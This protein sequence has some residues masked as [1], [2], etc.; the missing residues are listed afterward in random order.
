[1]LEQITKFINN[2]NKVQKI[3]VFGGIGL[4]AAIIIGFLLFTT[5]KSEDKKL[6]FIIASNLTQADVMRAS[7]E[8]EAAGIEFIITGSGS[9]LTLK[10]SQEFVNIAKIKLVTSEASTN[11]H[12]GWEIFEKSTIGTTNFENKVK[13]LRALEGE[14]SKSLEALSS[15]LKANVKIAIPK[16]TIFTEKKADTTASAVITLRQGLYLTQKQI[17]GIKNFIASAV[18]ELKV[19]N[20]QLIDS[21]G[22]LLEL[23]ADD[24]NNQRS[25]IQTKYKEKFE[26]DYE[27]KIIT[28][29]EPVVGY[30]RVVAKVNVNLDFV[31]KDIEEE[32]FAP[33]GTVRSQQVIESSNSATGM[34]DEIE[35]VGV[36]NNIQPPQ[37]A[38]EGNKVSSEGESSNTVTNYEISRKL[39]SQK[40]AN[41]TNIRRVTAS[42][43]FDSMVLKDHPNKEEF[44]SSLES[45]VE[46]AIGYDKNRGDKVSVKD[47]KFVGLK[48]YNENGELVDEFG[49]V[50]T[51]ASK[52]YLSASN[53]KEV[54]DEYKDYIQYL[55]VG[56]ILFIFYRRF[57]SNSELVILGEGKKE[58]LTVDDDDLVKDMLAGL[59]NELDQNTA[60]G[61]LKTKVKSQILNN[62]DGLDEESA[63]K[64][65]VFIEELDREINN[66]P[67]D[68][69]R[70]IE[71]LLSEGN[72]NFK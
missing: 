28:L 47:F 60:Q 53:I 7:E 19:E 36:D 50:I 71:L 16:E 41:F 20:I 38:N 26:E 59:E 6:N 29:L 23:N 51:D 18:S 3:A 61:R 30:G 9:N 70:M 21:D 34:P 14:L 15:V 48:S 43:S 45:L 40:D 1:M 57:V 11:K 33:Q 2:L 32:I 65:E 44:L 64:Y 67:A 4:L 68:I 25:T 63:A 42:V 66:N 58:E 39:I 72:V 22:N 27:K 12:V 56:L 17:D 49:N 46:D 13:Y 8:L 35:V 69:A 37:V 54:L 52:T 31:R 62:I 10:T 24:I 55:I 5:L